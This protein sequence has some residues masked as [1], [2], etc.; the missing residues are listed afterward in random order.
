MNNDTMP[1]V[2]TPTAAELNL[3]NQLQ[4]AEAQV[5]QLTA[6]VGAVIQQR[7]EATNKLA[8]ALATIA[9]SQQ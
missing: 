8:D 5:K 9:M 4:N 7:D 2:T 3:T 6:L 1:E